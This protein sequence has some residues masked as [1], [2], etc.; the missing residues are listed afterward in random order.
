[1]NNDNEKII[2]SRDCDATLIPFGN[3]FTLKKGDLIFTGTPE[4]VSKIY[5]GDLLEGFIE[6]EKII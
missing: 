4:G 3:A 2:L 5:K 6:N 1:M